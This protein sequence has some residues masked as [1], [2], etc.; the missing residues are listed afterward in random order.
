MLKIIQT[1]ADADKELIEV[2]MTIT[3]GIEK[4]HEGVSLSSG[5]LELNFTES[6]VKFLSI[7]L[8]IAVEGIEVSESSSKTSNGLSTT[9]L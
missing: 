3:V 6:G 5:D 8:V 1:Y 4:S 9:C 7:D 2:D